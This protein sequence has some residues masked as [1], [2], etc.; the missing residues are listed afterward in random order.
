VL[1]ISVI[2]KTF[3]LTVTGLL[4]AIHI[5]TWLVSTLRSIGPASRIE[6]CDNLP[7]SVGFPDCGRFPSIT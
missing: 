1:H 2:R 6:S 7:N 3:A 5:H 4:H